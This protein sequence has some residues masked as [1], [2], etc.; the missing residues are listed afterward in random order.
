M[1]PRQ[2]SDLGEWLQREGITSVPK[3]IQ[4]QLLRQQA[5]AA[6]VSPSSS[7]ALKMQTS[8]STPTLSTAAA[9]LAVEGG[10]AGLGESR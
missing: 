5:E 2:R 4:L 10:T 8:S 9:V 3:S 7:H 1:T 6:A